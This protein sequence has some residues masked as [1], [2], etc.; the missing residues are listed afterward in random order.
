MSDENDSEKK[1]LQA[2]LAWS[3]KSES[4]AR[5]NAMIDLARS[6]PGI[7]ILPDQLDREPWLLNVQNGSIELRTGKLRE[8]RR[9]D[10]I[11]KLAPVEY[12]EAATCP[13]W[14]GFLDR[15]MDHNRD[16]MGYLQRAVGYSLTGD[17]SEQV[18][19]F[20]YG[21][22]AN[23]KSTFLGAILALLGDYAMQAVS[24]LLM[25]KNHEAHPTER[26]DLF[27]KRFVCTIE[28]EEGKRLAEALMKQMTGGDRMR[29]RRMREDF[30]EFP[31]THKIF[32]AANHKP[33]VRGTDHAVWRRIKLVPFTV[34][35]TDAEKDRQLPEKLKKEV[36]PGLQWVVYSVRMVTSGGSF[37]H[38]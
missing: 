19:W 17:V 10:Y 7:P 36:L 2:I 8:H 18:I 16:V 9:D 30:W 4:A 25:A 20:L 28:T 27:G 32:L 3:F 33:T 23:G 13:T 31:P 37:C 1:R 21:C 12:D 14:D 15:I 24:D 34:R 11:T 5:I 29:A 35:I 38:A 26:A 22:G 6:E